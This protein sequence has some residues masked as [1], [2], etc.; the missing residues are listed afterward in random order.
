MTTGCGG[1]RVGARTLLWSAILAYA[2]A[3][4]A[5]S[6][7]R[8]LAFNTGRFDLG[9]MTQAVWA[10]AHGHPLRV[11]DVRGDQISRLASHVDPILAAFAPLWWVWPSPSMLLVV[12]AILVSLG[13][14]PVY[15]LARKHL[16]SERAA[17]GFAFAYLLYPPVQWLTLNEFHAVALACPLLLFAFWYLDEGRLW[18]FAAFAVLA[19]LTKEQ[20][21][22]IVAGLGVWYA[23]ARGR[24]L[25]GVLIAG[26]GVAFAAAAVG[27]VIPHFNDGSPSSFYSRYREVGGSPTGILRTAV[28]DPLRLLEHAF[29][30]AGLR[31]LAELVVPLAL[32]CLLAPLAALAAAPELALNLLSRTPTQQSIHFHY[33]AGAI[34]PLMAAAVLGAGRIV[35]RRPAAALPL[36]LVAVVIALGANFRLGPIPLWRELPWGQQL[37]SRDI[38]VS[39]HDRIARRAL[40]VIPDGAVVSA[41]NSLGAHLSARRRILSFPVLRDATWVAVDETR[42]S[43]ADRNEPLPANRRLAALRRNPAWKLVFQADGVL[44]FRRVA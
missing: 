27:L 32:L 34:P 33:T 11:T 7:L 2:A 13:A 23:L 36:A 31:Y 30:A 5:L 12:Q 35:R 3:F 39:P 24:R 40:R 17:L 28:T 21:A 10:T 19:A 4:S 44:V 38:Q 37:G 22:L 9:N 6:V 14:L 26:S 25:A 29:D 43:F 1:L 41:S 18:A 16:G 20:I 8:H 15:W 42:P